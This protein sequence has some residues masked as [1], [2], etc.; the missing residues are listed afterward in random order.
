MYFLYQMNCKAIFYRFVFPCL[1]IS[2]F[3]SVSTLAEIDI[4]N[5]WYNKA[6]VLIY[7]YVYLAP[8]WKVPACTTCNWVSIYL[9]VY[10]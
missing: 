4:L 3:D 5:Y 6:E 8:W 1:L 10:E 9:Y 2:L 7:S